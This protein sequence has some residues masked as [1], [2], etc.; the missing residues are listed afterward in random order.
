MTGI[1]LFFKYFAYYFIWYFTHGNKSDE[2]Y[3]D[4][5]LYIDVEKEFKRDLRFRD[6]E[7]VIVVL[8]IILFLFSIRMFF[9]GMDKKTFT[10][11][12]M[13]SALLMIACIALLTVTVFSVWSTVL[14]IKEL[15]SQS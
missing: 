15:K 10:I 6:V 4:N 7:R 9:I 13:L 3:Y 1:K 8:N 14:K 2:Y 5:E 11:C 12:F